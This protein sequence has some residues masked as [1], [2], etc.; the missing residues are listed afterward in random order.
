IAWEMSSR[1]SEDRAHVINIA[2]DE[3]FRRRGIGTEMLRRLFERLRRRHCSGCW[4]EVRRS[5]LPAQS[6]YESMGMRCI[7]V[8]PMYYRNEDALIYSVSFRD[9]DRPTNRGP[10]T[11]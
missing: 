9:L 5:N 7:G 1:S 10:M 8:R 4:L 2:V 6:L 3:R 11:S